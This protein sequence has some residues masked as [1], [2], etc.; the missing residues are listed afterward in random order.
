MSSSGDWRGPHHGPGGPGGVP[1]G[2]AVE[3]PKPGVVPLRPL[4]VGEIISGVFTTVQRYP[5][6][7]LVPVLWTA[8]GAVAAFGAFAVVAAAALDGPW[9]AV[10]NEE[11]PSTADAVAVTVTVAGA[12]LLLMVVLT[13]LYAVSSATATVVLRYAVI[14]RRIATRAV[15]AEARPMLWRVVATQVLTGLLAGGIL[16][17]SFLLPLLA[18]LLFGSETG[19]VLGVLFFVPG[20]AAAVYVQVRLVL[21]VP[22]LVL[23]NARPVAA[24]RRAWRL[25]EG[26][27]WRSL[28]IPYIVGLVGSFAAQIVAVP[29]MVVGMFVLFASTGNAAAADPYAQSAAPGV[30]ALVTFAFCTVTGVV[31]ATALTVPLTPLTNGL[32]YI[33]RRIRRESLDVT[34][35]EAAGLSGGPAAYVPGQAGA[36]AAE[37][38]AAQPTPDQ[39]PTGQAP[40][41]RTPA[42][43]PQA[44]APGT[45]AKQES[46]ED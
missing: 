1:W 44:A 33:D 35:A 31:L 42:D 39:T 16:V 14:G 25:N 29:C 32:L 24:L 37:E 6:Q 3:A 46:G 21:E 26:N 30:G 40:V 17:V 38:T 10:R 36:P 19:L 15:W 34:L 18:G 5:A 20:W 2:Y 7:L 23:E 13:A 11:L 43:G 4:G 12:V 28:G 27:W 8:L 22:V 41:D 9:Q 45:A